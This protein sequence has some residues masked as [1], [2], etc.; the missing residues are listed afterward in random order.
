M[1]RAVSRR[2]FVQLEHL[3]RPYIRMLGRRV[4]SVVV[5][6]RVV[7][8]GLL[9]RIQTV[10]D[11]AAAADAA[12]IPLVS[13]T[14]PVVGGVLV[15]IVGIVSRVTTSSSS[16]SVVTTFAVPVAKTR[17]ILEVTLTS[18]VETTVGILARGVVLP[19][20][21][22]QRPNRLLQKSLVE[23][24]C[25]EVGRR[26]RDYRAR[27][28]STPVAGPVLVHGSAS[29]VF[30]QQLKLILFHGTY[31]KCEKKKQL[32]RCFFSLFLYISSSW[33]TDRV[34]KSNVVEVISCTV[35]CTRKAISPASTKQR[36]APSYPE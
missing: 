23:P 11:A 5:I 36:N 33:R 35:V 34:R 24:T 21:P 14:I 17:T 26:G 30:A 29:A 32:D 2:R 4:I 25:V 1:L 9:P 13:V 15:R 18:A 22:V 7:V 3:D 6:E 12:E 16:S 10:A 28:Y 31:I 27:R 20:A 8:P 19:A